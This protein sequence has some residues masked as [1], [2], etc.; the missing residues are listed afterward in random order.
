MRKENNKISTNFGRWRDMKKLIIVSI[1]LTI[2][3]AALGVVISINY[4]REQDSLKH[5]TDC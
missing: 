3:I 2:A 1:V 4:M 5:E